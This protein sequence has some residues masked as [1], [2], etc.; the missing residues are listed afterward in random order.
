M[1][2]KQYTFRTDPKYVSIF[3]ELGVDLVTVANNHALDFGR[4]AFCDT[5]DTLKDADITCVGGGY[6]FTEASA[7]AV[8]TVHGQSFAIFAATRVSPSYDWYATDSQGF[9]RL[10]TL[11]D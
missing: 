4:D 6:N 2:D 9:F 7:P 3:Q 1:E 5:L 10:T 8:S 11:P